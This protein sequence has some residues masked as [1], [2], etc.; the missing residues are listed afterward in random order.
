[1]TKTQQYFAIEKE[2]SV[3]RTRVR[4]INALP[5]DKL[6]PE[7]RGERNTLYKTYEDGESK[8]KA[9]LEALQVEQAAGLTVVDTEARELQLLTDKANV[10]DILTASVEHRQT[11]G[12]AAELQQHHGLAAHQIPLE[13]LRINRGV[14]E[15][16]AA[17]VPASVGD[18]SQGEVVTPIFAS[19]D[20]AFLGIERP[21]VGVGDAAFPVLSTAPSVKGPF[22]DSS[23]AAQ[24][25]ATYVANTL[26]PERLQ[27]S[28]A[29]RRSDMARFSSLDASLRLALNG[30]LQEALDQQAINGDDGLLNGSNLSNNN[31]TSLT[32]FAL[33]LSAL[34]YARV[35]GRYARS[36]SDVRILV[37]QSA[38]THA[39][40]VY[41]ASETDETAAERLSA[42]SGGLVVSPHVPGISSKRQNTLIRLGMERGAAVQ[43]M[44]QGVS[45]I[46][47]EF[48]RTTQ[49]EIVVTAVLLANFA[50]TRGAQWS[51]RQIQ[52][53]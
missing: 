35:D 50:I 34:L 44:W 25:D 16:A 13:M 8:V 28:Y 38:F 10:G 32:T 14:E 49:G 4:E 3:I 29:Y 33:Y 40:S 2:R 18:A 5:D 1:M 15:R 7:L 6:T 19:G 48:T 17:T 41:K 45:L 27:A 31:V 43:P 26:S 46:V 36:P 30:G 47:D 22:T 9:S 52:I 53:P 42:R 51:K 39:S 20:G 21:V 23:D 37:G 11:T 24:T 12:E